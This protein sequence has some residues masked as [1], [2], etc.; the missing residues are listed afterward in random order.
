M[1]IFKRKKKRFKFDGFILLPVLKFFC[2][3]SS[4]RFELGTIKRYEFYETQTNIAQSYKTYIHSILFFACEKTE[5]IGISIQCHTTDLQLA[6][7]IDSAEQYIALSKAKFIKR[8][9]T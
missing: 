8:L 5:L 6:F 7:G 2:K 9:Y 1:V 4:V 3:N